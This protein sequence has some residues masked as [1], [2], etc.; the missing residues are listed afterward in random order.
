MSEKCLMCGQVK[1]KIPTLTEDFMQLLA[2]C[3]AGGRNSIGTVHDYCLPV[4]V[5]QKMIGRVMLADEEIAEL[6][7]RLAKRGGDE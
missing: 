5:M 6:R 4:D 7:R 3:A 1:N 2:S